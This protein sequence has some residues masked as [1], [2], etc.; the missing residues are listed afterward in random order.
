MRSYTRQQPTYFLP[1]SR[2]HPTRLRASTGRGPRPRVSSRLLLGQSSFRNEY[3]DTTRCPKEP[4]RDDSSRQV[5]YEHSLDDPHGPLVV[6]GYFSRP[7]RKLLV[8]LSPPPAFRARG[9]DPT[10]PQVESKPCT[11][12][13]ER[14]LTPIRTYGLCPAPAQEFDSFLGNKLGNK[15]AVSCGFEMY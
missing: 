5:A 1:F 8:P 7:S 2:E 14:R 15:L 9:V 12:A 3:M 13:T 6:P 11:D 4:P 10:E